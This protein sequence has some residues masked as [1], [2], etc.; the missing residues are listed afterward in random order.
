MNNLISDNKVK[1]LFL[2]IIILFSFYRSPYIFL[3]G[4]FFAEEGYVY[5][6]NAFD[7]GFFKNIFFVELEAGY[8]NL[9]AN[10]LIGLAVKI[11]I[12]NAPYVTVYGSF[13][14]ILTPIYLILFRH[15]VLF[16]N[17]LKKFTGVLI[18]FV[19]TPL[20]PEIWLNSINLQVYLCL[21]SI[22]V[23][24]INETKLFQKLFNSFIIFLGSFS[25][26]YTCALTPFFLIKFL[27]MKNNY[28]LANLIVLIIGSFVQIFLIINSK[29]NFHLSSTVLKIDTTIES[30]LLF[31]Y[32]IIVRPITGREIGTFIFERINEK[33]SLILILSIFLFLLTL[34]FFS[35][36]KKFLFF[37]RNDF[38]LLTLSSIF[39]VISLIII[40]GSIGSYYGGRYATIPGI[41]FILIIFHLAFK[42][43]QIKRLL[44]SSILIISIISG[45]NEFRP[46]DKE[47]SYGLKLLECLNCPEWKN[48]ISKWKKDNNY[49]IKIWPYPR[50]T[51]K[52]NI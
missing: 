36:R 39:I 50:K 41:I 45:I 37:F 51:M 7:L 6:Q 10:L 9:V 26:I 44:F 12:E 52:L 14:F 19:S 2:T 46:Y 13:F 38:I 29:I 47:S 27:K 32:N 23:L 15:S 28:N 30:I 16:D 21:S 49:E 48:E 1:F 18:F 24:F 11:P 33:F 20:V 35:Y 40:F 5:L 31:F 3:N 34:I 8:I 43:V 4:R 17:N 42:T 22:I 25:G